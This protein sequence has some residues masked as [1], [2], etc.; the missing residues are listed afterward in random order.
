MCAVF[1]DIVWGLTAWL[2]AVICSYSEVM[3]IVEQNACEE[4]APIGVQC[5]L[6]DN[7]T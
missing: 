4:K 3:I 2:S 7:T 6:A 1:L 5:R